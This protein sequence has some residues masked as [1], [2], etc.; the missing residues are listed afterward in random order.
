[1]VG[2]LQRLCTFSLGEMLLG[3]SV[4]QVQEVVLAQ[5]TTRVPLA[6]QTVA[7]LIN[8][9]GQI[10]TAIDLRE[11]LQL[12]PRSISDRPINVI[13]YTQ[14]EPV[15]FIVDRVGD[16]LDIEPSTFAPPPETLDGPASQFITGAYKLDG[17]LLLL[18]DIMKIVEQVTRDHSPDH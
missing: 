16:V 15:S 11:C 5:Q 6:K 9:R 18:L 4:E 7:G 2:N 8:L 14:H 13:V 12:P 3:I 10:V 1:M 17:Q